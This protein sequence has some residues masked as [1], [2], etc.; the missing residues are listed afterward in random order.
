MKQRTEPA[1]L[2]PIW[3]RDLRHSHIGLL[4]KKGMLPLVIAQRGARLCKYNHGYLR[5]SLSEQAE[6]GGGYVECGGYQGIGKQ[7]GG[8][9]NRD[10]IQKDWR[11][12]MQMVRGFYN[13]QNNMVNVIYYDTN[14]VISLDCGKWGGLQTTPNSQGKMDALDDLSVW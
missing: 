14:H 5:T 1:K 4:I 2:K 9:G 6:A 12:D 13:E 10:V 7:T 3:V 11:M 8:H